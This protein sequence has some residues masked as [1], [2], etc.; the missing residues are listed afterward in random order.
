MGLSGREKKGNDLLQALSVPVRGPSTNGEVW[1]ICVSIS[2]W[3]QSP[4]ALQ[5]AGQLLIH[6]CPTDQGCWDVVP[7]WLILPTFHPDVSLCI[8]IHALFCLLQ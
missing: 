1:L 3:L 7:Q 8:Y 4:S 2:P 5:P 6:L